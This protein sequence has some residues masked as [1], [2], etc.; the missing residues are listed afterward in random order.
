MDERLTRRVLDEKA[1]HLLQA[2]AKNATRDTPHPEGWRRF[3]DFIIYIHRRRLYVNGP[4][5]K[6]HL[7]DYGVTIHAARRDR[8][9]CECEET[10]GS[11]NSPY[12]TR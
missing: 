2:F 12:R 6:D 4:D 8:L 1:H 5:V 3:Y 9:S 10:P 11:R 7:V